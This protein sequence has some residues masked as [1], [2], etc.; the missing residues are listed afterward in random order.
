MNALA[1]ARL[2]DPLVGSKHALR[3][4]D[5]L[6]TLAS[7]VNS[8]QPANDVGEKSSSYDELVSGSLFWT[9]KDP[10]TFAGGRN[11]YVYAEDDPLNRA[12]T[13]GLWGFALGGTFTGSAG[14]WWGAGATG[15]VGIYWDSE[16][17]AGFYGYFGGALNGPTGGFG[18]VIGA[19]AG[20]GWQ[21]TLFGEF[22]DF[23][24]PGGGLGINTPGPSAD[25][26]PGAVDVSNG[27][28]LG[29][30]LHSFSTKTWTTPPIQLSGIIAPGY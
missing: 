1:L 26:C 9:Q 23:S 25:I 16:E 8:S 6:R 19:Y 29:A 7:G 15:G 18:A 20:A 24:G 10:V 2:D 3:R 22:G 28:G 17:G 11:L 13:S 12:D 30:D 21:V 4:S 5:F 14:G 27:P